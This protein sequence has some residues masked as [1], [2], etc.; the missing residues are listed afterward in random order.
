MA[1]E[2]RRKR[3]WDD[4]TPGSEEPTK[5][6]AL[7]GA[8]MLEVSSET[9]SRPS[10]TPAS[11][12]DSSSSAEQAN[13]AAAAAAAIAA[14]K[15]NALLV[16]KGVAAGELGAESGVN[17]A[18]ATN[19]SPT[20]PTESGAP[21]LG[22]QSSS[23][24]HGQGRSG[25]KNR[26]DREEFFVDIDINDVKRR[27]M[28]TKGSFQTQ[29]QRDTG[30]DVTTRGKYYPDRSTAT[31]ADPPLYL[32]ISAASQESLDKAVAVINGIIDEGNRSPGP[33]QQPRSFEPRHSGP[34]AREPRFN[35]NARVEVDIE[36]DRNFNARAKIVGPQGRY[37]KHVQ[38]E[39]R[40]RVQLKGRGSG[41][42]EVDTG[43]ELDEPLF[44]NIIGHTQ[45]DVDRATA[46]CEDLVRTVREEYER[47]KSRPPQEYY[48]GGRYGGRPG[49][50]PNRSYDRHS[51]Y[52]RGYHHQQHQQHQYNY[53]QSSYH[54]APP[55]PPP[56]PPS[57]AG[58]N[59]PL[60]PGPPP[61]PPPAPPAP[62]GG[63]PPASTGASATAGDAAQSSSTPT[64]AGQEGTGA[65]SG[66]S[67]AAYDPYAAYYYQNYPGYQQY[68]QQYYQY[69][70]YGQAAASGA[71]PTS[72][73]SA[74]T[75]AVDP[76]M[77]HYG[78]GYGATQTTSTSASGDDS[79]AASAPEAS[80]S[81]QPEAPPA[82]EP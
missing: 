15:A 11:A 25:D 65:A 12:V 3:K 37:V 27:Y 72:G 60:P 4:P 36:S 20:P 5:R 43:R 30:A 39:T 6:A 54:G 16:A 81:S 55:P 13:T 23:Q 76:A 9:D 80:S 34:L 42:L 32:H 68:L 62:S 67:N 57:E 52:D 78:Y 61:P 75:S 17:N 47:Y 41:Y 63:A 48:G 21:G 79:A 46:L 22:S 73:A 71:P 70:G 69:Y 56:P 1:D 33:E 44:I 74:P 10:S 18:N 51:S 58:A 38:E 2:A 35:Y 31:A 24:G 53:N 8:S 45:E 50:Y 77:A 59:P 82:S 64:T 40:T 7:D 14:A 66:A 26:H 49:Y 28:L 19:L 29:I